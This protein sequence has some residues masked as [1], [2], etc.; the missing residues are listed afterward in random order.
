MGIVVVFVALAQTVAI[1]LS[2]LYIRMGLAAGQGTWNAYW[3]TAEKKRQREEN[4]SRHHSYLERG[5]Y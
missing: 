3:E 2:L 5:S 4:Y 1:C